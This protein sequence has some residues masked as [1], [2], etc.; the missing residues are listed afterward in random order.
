LA[1]L[2]NA[3]SG[4]QQ[5]VT[6]QSSRLHI[7]GTSS[8]SLLAE[9]QA[10]G[11]VILHNVG[12][13]INNVW[14]LLDYD[15]SVLEVQGPSGLLLNQVSTLPQKVDDIRRM[16][17]QQ[18]VLAIAAGSDSQE[19][20]RTIEE[21]RLRVSALTAELTYPI[22]PETSMVDPTMGLQAGQVVTIP[23]K[24]RRVGTGPSQSKLV[25][26]LVGDHEYVRHEV[27]I[28]LP[29]AEKLR[30]EVDGTENSWASTHEGIALYLWPS[31]PT[32]YRLGM[33]NDSGKPRTL[34]VDLVALK[35]RREVTLPDGFL[36][37]S[38]SQ[39]VEDLL[40]QTR[41]IA[42]I[43]DLALD[44]GSNTVWLPLERLD[45]AAAMPGGDSKE[46]PSVPIPTDQGLVLVLTD[47]ATN[48]K[49]W[50]RVETRVRHPRS[51]VEPSVRFDAVSERAEIRLKARQPD[52]VPAKG[53]E[54]VG[55][56][57]E[58]LPRGTEMKLE[59][60]ILAGETAT[61]YCQVPS[62]SAR[63]L[64]FELDVDGF[65]RA[66][67]VKVP[68]WRTNTDIPI[69]SDYQKIEI[70]EPTNERSLGPNDQSQRVR[71]R[72][73]AIPGAFETKRD[74]VEVGWDLDR[75]REFAGET[76]VKFASDRQVDVAVN[77][78]STGRMSMTAKVSDI[79]FDLPPPALKNQRVNLLARLFAGGESVWSNPIEIIADSDPPTVTGVEITP[80]TTFPQGIDLQVRVGV[81]DAKLSGIASVELKIDTNGVSKFS[82]SADAPKPFSRQSDGSWTL[83][84]PTADLKPGRATLFVRATDRAGNSSDDSKTVLSIVSEQDWEQKLKSGSQELTGTVLYS[85]N[86]MTNAKVTL[87]DEKGVVVHKTN[88]DERGTFRVSG[89][90]AGKLKVV[91]IGVVKNRPRK[92][93]Q[94]VEVTAPPAPPV[95]LRLQAK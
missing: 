38:A 25:W 87:E 86:P 19:G 1:F 47:K 85:D 5:N 62:V 77:S 89:V 21:A 65:P 64:T 16:A 18:L 12:K 41:R 70:I 40:G 28:Q 15:P 4:S 92:A 68:C 44:S 84:I 45:S 95:R 42:S 49:Y 36:T 93:E 63:E 29:E 50:R 24:V 56:I 54:V 80:G 22:N 34:S 71:L 73:D 79:A 13:S 26:K 35:S 78:I 3:L 59:G 20:R 66:F 31:R 91:A 39:Q 60:T 33:R 30:L 88:T 23:F 81:D 48:K 94:T 6:R 2:A 69:A 8:I 67:V 53:I 55:R 57:L 83:S 72:I 37:S 7:R 90:Q 52:T 32:E 27:M 17:E 75:D 51:Y 74:Y 14:L 61:I 11:E 10:S 82:D 46:T 43:S 9:P 58:P 76:T